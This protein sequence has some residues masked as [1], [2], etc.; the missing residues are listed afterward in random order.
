MQIELQ[1]QSSNVW[2]RLMRPHTLTA[3]FVPVFAGTAMALFDNTI[4]IPLFIAML[5]ASILYITRYQYV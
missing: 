1:P 4:Y 3:S 5:V 2:W